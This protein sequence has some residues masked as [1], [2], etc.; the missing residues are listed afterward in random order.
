MSLTSYLPQ[1]PA[2]GGILPYWL[3]ITSIA[4][5]YNVAQ[6]YVTLKQSKEIYSGK[7]EQM[8][9]LAGRL[10]GAWT[11]MAAAIRLLAAYDISNKGLYDL[12]IVAFGV[13]TFHFVSE[14]LVFG[15]VKPNRASI[16][17]LVIGCE[18]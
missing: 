15:T 4:S 9:P 5:I 16:G 8:T 10:F 18:F 1:P 12:G 7:E 11:A 14:W 17:P 2:G 6:N 3:L 13:A